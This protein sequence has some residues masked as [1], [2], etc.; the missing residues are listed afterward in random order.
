MAGGEGPSVEQGAL[1]TTPMLPRSPLAQD[2]LE[3]RV[4]Q[5]GH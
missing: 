2:D 4:V 3:L 5:A 1:G